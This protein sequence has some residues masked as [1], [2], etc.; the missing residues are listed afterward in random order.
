MGDK[1]VIVLRVPV[2]T[3]CAI[4]MT[5]VGLLMV[6]NFTIG[7][8]ST[9]QYSQSTKNALHKKRLKMRTTIKI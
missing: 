8:P 4:S 1:I 6:S 5:K 2:N 3:Y 9:I 7:T